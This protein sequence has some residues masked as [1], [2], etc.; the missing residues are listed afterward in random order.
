MNKQSKTIIVLIIIIVAAAL[1][2]ALSSKN[3]SQVETPQT[4]QPVADDG[5]FVPELNNTLET[6]VTV[7]NPNQAGQ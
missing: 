4:E 6:S 1:I 5:K 2:W 3:G 7:V